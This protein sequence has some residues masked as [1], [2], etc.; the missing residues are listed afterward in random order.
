MAN[1]VAFHLGVCIVVGLL[2]SIRRSV[3]PKTAKTGVHR[4]I[5]FHT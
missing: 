1:A 4:D 3:N 5:I 2:L